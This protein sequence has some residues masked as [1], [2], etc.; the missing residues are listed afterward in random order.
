MYIEQANFLKT[1]R[2]KI[3]PKEILEVV[4]AGLPYS[5]INELKRG[6]INSKHE[7]RRCLSLAL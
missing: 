2:L 4:K 3:P 6:S 7:T 5:E 1:P